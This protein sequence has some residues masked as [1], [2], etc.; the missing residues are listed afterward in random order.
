MYRTWILSAVAAMLIFAIA[1]KIDTVTEE[2]MSD[3]CHKISGSVYA[4]DRTCWT[5][6]DNTEVCSTEEGRYIEGKCHIRVNI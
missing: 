2:I 1:Y 4:K 5:P 6:A 3:K